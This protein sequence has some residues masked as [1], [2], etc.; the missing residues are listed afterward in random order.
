LIDVP[1]KFEVSA[2]G[3]AMELNRVLLPL[4]GWPIKMTVGTLGVLM[5]EFDEDLLGD[6]AAE[7]YGRVRSA[8]ADKERTSEYGLSVELDDVVFV[9]SQG[10]QAAP[11][12][13]AAGK[14]DDPQGC[15]MGCIDE[16]HGSVFDTV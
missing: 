6:P 5:D 7:R 16:V 3:P 2:L 8:V 12:V 4:L 15:V 1:G 9:E 14:V 13:F 11:D 10:H